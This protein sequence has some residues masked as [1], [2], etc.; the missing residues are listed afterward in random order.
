M[1]RATVPAKRKTVDIDRGLFL[2]RYSS[3]DDP[4]RPPSVRI[5]LDADSA[6]ENALI[7]HPDAH[8]AVL[9]E[10]GTALAVRAVS[11][12]RLL[13]EVTPAGEDGSTAA[14][15]K[16]EA[17]NPGAQADPVS[18]TVAL[19]GE[20]GESFLDK[21]IRL[22]AH[23]AGIGDVVATPQEWI[24]GPAAPSRIEGIAVE[25]P[26]RPAGLGLRYAV[27]GQGSDIG[28]LAEV[29]AFVGT[30]GRALPLTDLVLELSGEAAG[31]HEIVVDALFLGA[32]VTRTTGRRVTLSGPTAREPLVGLRLDV[33]RRA[34]MAE[35]AVPSAGAGK[36]RPGQV[37]VFRGRGARAQPAAM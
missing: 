25:W 10:P 9:F 16:V 8:E 4:R 3:A 22:R 21:S 34:G 23:V 2:V 20:A 29:G 5:A 19:A 31:D 33:V 1:K 13:V 28:R 35:P 17:L 11:P 14:T 7:T 26:D 32:P 15:V 24:A 37:R 18:A 12:T 6:P 27:R 30:R 36:T